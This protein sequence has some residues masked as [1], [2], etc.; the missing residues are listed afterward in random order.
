MD[1][2]V[3]GLERTMDL[4]AWHTDWPHD[5]SAYEVEILT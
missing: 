4:R 2:P 5:L 3:D 1:R